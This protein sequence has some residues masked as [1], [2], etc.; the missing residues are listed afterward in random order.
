MEENNE[1]EKNNKKHQQYIGDGVYAYYDGWGIR[2]IAR[3]SDE[4]ANVIYLE[5][6]V[7]GTLNDF[8][9]SCTGRSE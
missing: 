5:P 6:R 9:K 7:L 3:D 2:L 8:Y 1:I 4:I